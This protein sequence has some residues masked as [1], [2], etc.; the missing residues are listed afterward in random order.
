MTLPLT[1]NLPLTNSAPPANFLSRFVI[2]RSRYA[3]ALHATPDPRVTLA[4][5]CGS[6]CNPNPD[7]DP[8]PNPNPKPKPNPNPNPNPDPNPN[9]NP[10]PDPN[11]N[12]NP[13][14]AR[15]AIRRACRSSSWLG[16]CLP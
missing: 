8:D 9:P 7:P 1:V 3:F 12:P 2:P 6:C 10:N 16:L 15:A 13:N 14:Q 11:P 4:L 5:N